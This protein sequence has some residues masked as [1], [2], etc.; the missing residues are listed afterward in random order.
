MKIRDWLKNN[1]VFFRTIFSVAAVVVAIV[2]LAMSIRS[3]RIALEGTRLIRAEKLPILNF[4]SYVLD[5]SANGGPV[6][7]ELLVSNVGSPVRHI[8]VWPM[9]LLQIWFAKENPSEASIWIP[10]VGYYLGSRTGHT[11]GELAI[12]KSSVAEGNLGKLNGLIEGLSD[13][14]AERDLPDFDWKILKY[15]RVEYTDSLGDTHH[16]V[17]LLSMGKY[18][19]TWEV[20]VKLSQSDSEM[21]V[22]RYQNKLMYELPTGVTIFPLMSEE[23][24]Y[25]H[26]LSALSASTKQDS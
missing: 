6:Q 9:V 3:N 4:A 2:A 15:L 8:V 20:N 10:L 23:L 11:E 25:E 16:E 19:F 12:F 13:L 5:G 14:L 26:C 7:E 18:F 22:N 21:I 17:Y 24:F 1:E